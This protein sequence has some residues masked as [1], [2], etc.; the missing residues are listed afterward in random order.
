[1]FDTKKLNVNQEDIFTRPQAPFGKTWENN[2]KDIQ[3]FLP[4][5]LVIKESCNLIG[6]EHS[7]DLT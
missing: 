5:I 7:V 2:E 1:M 6:Q 3:R 4:D